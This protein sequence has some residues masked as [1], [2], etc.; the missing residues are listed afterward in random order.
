MHGGQWEPVARRVPSLVLGG[1]P[2]LYL[3]GAE[4]ASPVFDVGEASAWVRA[5]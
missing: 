1:P 4:L 5:S 3:G 2:T